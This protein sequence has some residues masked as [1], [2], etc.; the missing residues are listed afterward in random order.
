MDCRCSQQV[1]PSS[2]SLKHTH[3]HINTQTEQPPDTT[4]LHVRGLRDPK[5]TVKTGDSKGQ[6]ASDGRFL[7][8]KV[9]FG[10]AKEQ[11]EGKTSLKDK[12]ETRMEMEK[13]LI[14]LTYRRIKHCWSKYSDKTG[15]RRTLKICILYEI[16]QPLSKQCCQSICSCNISFC[17]KG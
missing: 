10:K 15:K 11:S 1:I 14:V 16:L 12:R 3:V 13:L 2:L 8:N 7:F 17:F 6:R 4:L 5:G 9:F